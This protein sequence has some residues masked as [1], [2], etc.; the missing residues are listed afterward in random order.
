VTDLLKA[1]LGNDPVNNFPFKRLTTIVSVDTPGNNRG[2]PIAGKLM[3]IL[4]GPCGCVIKDTKAVCS[5]SNSIRQPAS[6]LEIE[7]GRVLE[8]RQSKVIEKEMTRRLHSDLK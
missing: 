5:Q 2:Y 6:M 7:L 8:N 4:C 3:C 1:V